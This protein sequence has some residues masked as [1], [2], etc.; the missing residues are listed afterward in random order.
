[1]KELGFYLTNIFVSTAVLIQEVMFQYDYN[2]LQI[3]YIDCLL[4][5]CLP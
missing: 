5:Y 4:F 2:Q 3:K 1:M